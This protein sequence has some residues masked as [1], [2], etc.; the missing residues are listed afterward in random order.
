MKPGRTEWG[1]RP[2]GST[3]ASRRVELGRWLAGLFIGPHDPV[4]WQTFDDRGADPALACH[5]TATASQAFDRLRELNQQG[6]GVFAMV[7]EGDGRGRSSRNVRRVRALFIDVDR[8]QRP[9]SVHL[10]PSMMV[11]SGRGWHVYWA[12]TDCPLD[13]FKPLQRRLA[14]KYNSDKAITDLPRVM[15]AAGFDHCKGQRKRVKLRLLD[16]WG[17]HSTEAVEAGLPSEFSPAQLLRKAGKPYQPPEGAEDFGAYD[18]V[19][20]F[21]ARTKV[22]RLLR[23]GA[24]TVLCPWAD[25]HSKLLDPDRATDTVA[26]PASGGAWP[27][28]HCSHNSCAGRNIVDVLRHFGELRR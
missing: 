22:G 28:F 21:A 7:N 3:N 11:A 8:P 25:Q 23:S 27:Q 10:Q 2:Q 17:L 16:P 24:Y 26:W 18:I 20:A 19:A 5:F 4:T 14:L 6:A 13:R 15:R 12:V 1:Q 9:A